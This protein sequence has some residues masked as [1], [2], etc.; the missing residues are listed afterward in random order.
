MARKE[1]AKRIRRMVPRRQEMRAGKVESVVVGRGVV[2][3]MVMGEKVVLSGMTAY[4]LKGTTTMLLGWLLYTISVM[5]DCSESN[6]MLGRGFSRL[7]CGEDDIMV[8]G[9]VVVL[10]QT[11][12]SLSSHCDPFLRHNRVPS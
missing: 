5:L 11:C 10:G 4:L 2:A 1:R 6:G 9:G 12:F 8:S 7:C 3:G